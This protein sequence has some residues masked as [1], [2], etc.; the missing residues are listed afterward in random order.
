MI[1]FVEFIC[2]YETLITSMHMAE[3]VVLPAAWKPK[4]NIQKFKFIMY[5]LMLINILQA[6][7]E[8]S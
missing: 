4:N 6:S 5:G 1:I 3:R 7:R 2:E 8:I